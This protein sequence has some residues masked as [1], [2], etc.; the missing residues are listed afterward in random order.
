LDVLG[1]PTRS[2]C[3]RD[4]LN[5]APTHVHSIFVMQHGLFI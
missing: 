1:V 2:T 5:R 3:G 4:L